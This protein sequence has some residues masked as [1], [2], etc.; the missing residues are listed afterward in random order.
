MTEHYEVIYSPMAKDD[1]KSIYSYIA[2]DLKEKGTATKQ[3]NRI[4]KSIRELD[5]MPARF[6]S[7]DWEPWASMGIRKMPVNNYVVF[8]LIDDPKQAVNIVR[9]FYGGRDVESIVRGETE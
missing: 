2:V 6:V 5:S 9:I 3:V 7:V 4:R 1:L 8:Y